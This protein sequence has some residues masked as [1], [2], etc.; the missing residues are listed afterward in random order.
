MSATPLQQPQPG[1]QPIPGPQ[2]G[3]MV[4]QQYVV[5]INGSYGQLQPPVN[6][7]AIGVTA[8]LQ[9]IITVLI[10]LMGVLGILFGCVNAIDG[11]PIWTGLCVRFFSYITVVLGPRGY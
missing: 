7:K 1:T 5:T 9:L 11:M 2:A 4:S 8:T 6:V 10:I 3:Q